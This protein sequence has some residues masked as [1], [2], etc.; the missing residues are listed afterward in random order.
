MKDQT[1]HHRERHFGRFSRQVVL[2]VPV[3]SD[4]AE[5]HFENGVLRLRLPKAEEAKE[6]KISIHGVSHS[7]PRQIEAA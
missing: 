5:A 3:K 2:P 4:D 7:G 1:F 6:R